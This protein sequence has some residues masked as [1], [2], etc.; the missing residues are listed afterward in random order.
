MREKK[1][2]DG[3]WKTPNFTRNSND[4]GEEN[5]CGGLKER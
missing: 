1:K 3:A 4:V 5:G 2:N